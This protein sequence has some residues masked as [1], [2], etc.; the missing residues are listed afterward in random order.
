MWRESELLKIN[1]AEV[2]RLVASTESAD[3]VAAYDTRVSAAIKRWCLLAQNHLQSARVL[4]DRS[5]LWRSTVSRAYYA[6]YNSSRAIRLYAYGRVKE[7][8]DDHRHVGELPDDFPERNQWSP[9]LNQLRFER[10]R[11]DYDPGSDVRTSLSDDPR[12]LVRRA[13]EFLSET[14]EYLRERGLQL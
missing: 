7:G 10:D 9:F 8:G 2:R 12:S 11:C 4:V 3:A 14:R 5:R 13:E 6:V 1:H